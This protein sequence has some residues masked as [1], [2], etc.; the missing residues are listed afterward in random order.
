MRLYQYKDGFRYTSDTMFLYDFAIR[1]GVGK[2]VLDVGAGCGILGLLIANYTN[3]SVTLIEKNPKMAELC[4]RNSIEN[5]IDATVIC[6]DFLNYK[7][8]CSF[9]WIVSNPP[10]YKNGVQKSKNQDMAMAKYAHGFELIKWLEAAYKILNT[11]GNLVF[12]YDASQLSTIYSIVYGFKQ[13]ASI[14]HLQF[15]HPKIDKPSKL[16]L[17]HVKKD[18]KADTKILRPI[19]IFENEQYSNTVKDIFLQANCLSMDM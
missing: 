9:D 3:A 7:F 17:I 4:K 13:K 11:K 14:A 2:S 15:I 19:I 8:E 6:D 18:S 16:V 12:C 1:L 5:S 10:Y